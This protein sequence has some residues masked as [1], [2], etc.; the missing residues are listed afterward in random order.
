MS[1]QSTHIFFGFFSRCTG[2]SWATA[3]GWVVLV[4]Q[5]FWGAE[6]LA[7]T[8]IKIP[9]KVCD[10]SHYGANGRRQ[11]IQHNTLQIQKAIDECA[12]A[13]GGTVLFPPGNYLSEPLFLKSHIR[14]HLV[15]GATLV[16]STVESSY[17]PSAEKIGSQAENGWLPF[18]SLENVHDVAITGEGTIDG[19][20][21]VWWERWRSQVREQPA[22]RGA[23]NRPRLIYISRSHHVL[24]QGVTISNSPSFHVVMRDSEHIDV[25]HTFITS[26]PFAPHTDAIDPINSRHIRITH[27]V[28]DTNDDHVA[29]KADKVDARYPEGATHDIYIAHNLLK[30]G[31]G[32]SIGSETLGG[33]SDILVEHN[34]F[35]GSMYGLRI[36]SPRG[37][38]GRV[39]NVIYRDTTMKNVGVP[40]IVSA[41]YQSAPED[42]KELDK[43]LAAGGF[44]VGDQVYPAESDPEQRTE[45]HKT[46]HFSNIR[47]THL[48]STGQSSSAGYILGVPESPISGL[49]LENVQ[50]QAE[51]GLWVRHARVDA[52]QLQLQV[53]SGQALVVQKG[54]HVSKP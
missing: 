23:T 18:I 26:P 51:R 21:A 53:N 33:V 42:A 37:K 32:I 9:D 11:Q 44:V 29:I 45:L 2:A 25:Q 50:I 28:I 1:T 24:V 10:V 46:P 6:V 12:A 3:C 47:I 39:N 19:Q 49:V 31:R 48:I 54:G 30:G 8:D 4:I 38:G 43:A 14:L 22:K 35:E 20:G 17:R 16:A 36:K 41:Y 15:K 5:G 13:G 34:Q 27:N 52:D 7:M 40:L